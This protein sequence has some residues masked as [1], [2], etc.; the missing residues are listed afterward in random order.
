MKHRDVI[1][2]LHSFFKTAELAI[3]FKEDLFKQVG[4]AIKE[5]RNSKQFM[6]ETG[7]KSPTEITPDNISLYSATSQMYSVEGLGAETMSRMCA[8]AKIPH[9]TVPW[10]GENSHEGQVLVVIPKKYERQANEIFSRQLSLNATHTTELQTLDE[11]QQALVKRISHDSDAMK[12]LVN[13]QYFTEMETSASH[14]LGLQKR[15][16]DNGIMCVISERPDGQ[17]TMYVPTWSSVER[18]VLLSSRISRRR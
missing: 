13:D 3:S 8:K 9:V 16:E 1:D 14:A 12:T 18:C 11:A 6:R 2:L 10:A 7:I 5:S 4:A 15:F 17:C